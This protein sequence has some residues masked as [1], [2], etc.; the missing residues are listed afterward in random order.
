MSGYLDHL[1]PQTH[2]LDFNLCLRVPVI[3]PS[4]PAAP[5]QGPSTPP[6]QSAPQQITSL[7]TGGSPVKEHAPFPLQTIT[8]F[9]KTPTV[10]LNYSPY[11]CITSR[12][13]CFCPAYR[14]GKFFWA[15]QLDKK[16]F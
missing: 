11:Q 8:S 2:D 5:A 15:C 3:I 16:V 10:T 4:T 6:S 7:A 14:E 13:F 1:C 12:I 9:S